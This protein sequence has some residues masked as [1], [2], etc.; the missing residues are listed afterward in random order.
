MSLP[1]IC[2]LEK[3]DQSSKLF[4]ATGKD[5][6]GHFGLFEFVIGTEGASP[7]P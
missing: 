2:N 6:N 7:H 4:K 1:V 3:G 5:T